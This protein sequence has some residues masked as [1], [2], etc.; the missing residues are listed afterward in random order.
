MPKKIIYLPQKIYIVS[1]NV[2]KNQVF[3]KKIHI[4]IASLFL[5]GAMDISAQQNPQYTQYMY[6][7]SVVNPAYAGSK[8]AVSMGALYRKQWAGFDGAPETGTFSSIVE[9]GRKLE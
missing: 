3:M 2:F 5:L 1:N 8:D 6:N 7:M 9:S 4:L